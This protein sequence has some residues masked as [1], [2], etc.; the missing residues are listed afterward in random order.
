MG[1]QLKVKISNE[2][3]IINIFTIMYLRLNKY[4]CN[5][6]NEKIFIKKQ[7]KKNDRKAYFKLIVKY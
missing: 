5:Y 2:T 6:N 4:G 7:H 1:K 3:N